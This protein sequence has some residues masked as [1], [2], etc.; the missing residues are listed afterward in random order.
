MIDIDALIKSALALFIIM[1]PFASLPVFLSLTKKQTD[2][3]KFHSAI[4]ATAIA[5]IVL[6]IFVLIGPP[7]ME[8]MA[9]SMPAFMVAGGVLLLIN[10]IISF[11]G[12]DFSN[13]EP[14]KNLDI[15]IVVVAVP[16][17]T[18][19]GAMTTAVILANQFGFIT[20]FPAIAL[21]VISIFLTLSLARPI[22][23][24]AGENGIEIFSKVFS[25]LL[26]AI[27][28]E[29]IKN[30]IFEIISEWGVI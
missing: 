26:A 16:L 28:I 22:S 11:F 29:F 3:Q 27:A 6:S 2:S 18:G 14:D 25:I 10:S 7:L 23:K 21:V 15:K 4:I 24:L 8:L 5:T 13:K 9:I 17:L 1:D 19:P 12:I 30:G 20:V